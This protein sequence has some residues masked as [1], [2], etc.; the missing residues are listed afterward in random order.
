[1]QADLIVLASLTLVGTSLGLLHLALAIRAF[2][3]SALGGF[4]SLLV[5]LGAPAV[6]LRSGARGAAITY[7]VF[8]IAYVVLL[9][10]ASR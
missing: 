7:G 10:L 5:P 9:L 1:V 4:V 3:S 2:R 6:A 8:V